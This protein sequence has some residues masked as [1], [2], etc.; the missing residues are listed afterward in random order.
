[1]SPWPSKAPDARFVTVCLVWLLVGLSLS[2]L[3]YCHYYWLARLSVS[4]GLL[5]RFVA[6]LL[7]F[8]VSLL[9][10]SLLLAL[11]AARVGFAGHYWSAGFAVWLVVR[12]CCHSVAIVIVITVVASFA[13][14]CHCSLS[15]FACCHCHCF[16]AWLSLVVVAPAIARC[17]RLL[18]SVS[19]VCLLFAVG[20]LLVVAV[21][22][23]AAAGCRLL[24][25]GCICRLEFGCRSRLPVST[26]LASVL[27]VMLVINCQLSFCH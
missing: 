21:A 22:F 26:L 9:S 7:G 10:L 16:T 25:L 24:L 2:L 23:V 15:L 19:S 17:R 20:W 13:T 6:G 27:L 4:A 8:A 14:G 3:G 18:V 1:M 5:A 12:H 11:P